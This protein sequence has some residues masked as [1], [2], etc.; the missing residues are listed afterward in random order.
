MR[1][2]LFSHVVDPLAG[3][4][5]PKFSNKLLIHKGLARARHIDA[6]KVCGQNGVRTE[7]K[8]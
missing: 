7:M 8:H 6:P 4:V 1:M 3:C 5:P 2:M